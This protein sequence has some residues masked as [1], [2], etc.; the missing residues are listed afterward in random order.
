MGWE[1]IFTCMRT[2]HTHTEGGEEREGKRQRERE[3]ER[4]REQKG[5]INGR[6][7]QQEVGR[8]EGEGSGKYEYVQGTV[9]CTLKCHSEI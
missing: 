1:A 6:R 5:I 3:R 8:R 7:G 2:P 9:M 4:E